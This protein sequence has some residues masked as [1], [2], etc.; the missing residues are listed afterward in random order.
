MEIPLLNTLYKKQKTDRD[1]FQ[2]LMPFKVK[3]IL[4]VATLYDAFSITSEGQFFDRIV[5]E[6]LQLNLYAAPRITSVSSDEEALLKLQYNNYD[7]IILTAG[8]NR[9]SPISLAAKIKKVTPEVPILLLVNNNSDLKY[10]KMQGGKSR[11]FERI[12]VWNGDSKI[13]LAMSKYVEDKTNA[14]ADTMIGNVRVILLVED[15]VR[16]YSRYL[17]LL[18]SIVMKQTQEIIHE[19]TVDELHKILKM[20]A[21]P[22]I[23]LATSY[24]EAIEIVNKYTENLLCVI[25]DVSF[26]KNGIP[27]QYSGVDLLNYVR[28]KVEI[29]ML[30]QSSNMKNRA[31][32]DNLNVDFIHKES[33]SLAHDIQHFLMSRCGFGDFIFKDIDGNPI[34]SATNLKEFQKKLELIPNESLLYHGSRNGFSTWLMARGEINLAKKLRPVDITDFTSVDALRQA[35]LDAF[36]NVRLKRLRGRVVR[37]DPSHINTRRYILRLGNGSFGGKGRGI[38]FLS[39]FIENINFE[40]LIPGIRIAVPSTAIIGIEEF[41]YFIDKNDLSELIY[42]VEERGYDFIKDRF[43][44]SELSPELKEI[45]FEYVLNSRKPLAIRSSGLFEDSFMQPFSGVYNTYLIP[46]NHKDVTVRFNQLQ[47]AVKLVYASIFSDSSRNYFNAVNYKIEEE[48]MAVIIQEVIGNTHENYFYSDMSGV[49]QSYNYYP[50]AYM[51][52]DDGFSVAAVGLGMYVVGGEKSHRF[53]P[54]YPKL[55]LKSLSDQIK[56]SQTYFYGLKLNNVKPE[57]IKVE[58]EN[59]FIEKLSTSIAEKDG[60]LENCAEVYDYQNERLEHDF[61]KKGPRVVN[62]ANILLYD[63]FPLANAI[64]TL[65]KLCTEAMGSPV[66][67]EYVVDFGSESDKKP[68][69]FLVQIKPLIQKELDVNIED[70]DYDESKA[71]LIASKGM[72]NGKFRNVKDV[73]YMNTD[74]FDRTKTDEMANEIK[75]MNRQLSAEDREYVLIGPGRWGTRDKFTGIPVLW[76]HISKARV[77]IEI[78]LKDFPLDASLGSHFFHNVTSMNVGYFSVPFN[79]KDNFINTEMLNG[80]EL[81]SETKYFKHVRFD[82]PLQ[83]I[84]DGKKRKAVIVVNE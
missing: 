68:T 29:P 7:M 46:N 28:D 21:R 5:G 49:A 33:E 22:K 75:I 56:D 34:D 36:E 54:R 24:E 82:K 69:L 77:I 57:D 4:L 20:R 39:D 27:S 16:Y 15:S 25:S 38:A 1:I 6:Y 23:L 10:F 44:H 48:K 37:F 83:I 60:V 50:F 64:E 65:L 80:G 47:S 84:L 8:L 11:N 51:E 74:N 52:P 45:L 32:A 12:F 19:H 79:S 17:P 62:F 72:G 67:L 41:E 76:S 9:L 55:E 59:Q 42:G 26:N 3:E 66:E 63:K 58:H 53:C 81:I 35:V 2:E 14:S 31:K 70:E 18:Y 78:G 43:L 73:I 40:K 13:F 71:L 30:M 61:E